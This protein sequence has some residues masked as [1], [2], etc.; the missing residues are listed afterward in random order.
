M[1]E[2]TLR[3]VRSSGLD[4]GGGVIPINQLLS[5]AN[6]DPVGEIQNGIPLVVAPAPKRKYW[7]ACI[8]F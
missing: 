3:I 2:E 6:D 4:S 1:R 8:Y 7:L 5:I